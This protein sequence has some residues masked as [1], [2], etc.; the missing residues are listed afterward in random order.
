MLNYLGSKFRKFAGN[1]SGVASIEFG[2]IAPIL[3]AS[4]V[5]TLDVGTMILDRTDMQ[6]AVRTGAQYLMNGGQNLER[7]RDLVME[8]WDERPEGGYVV[9]ENFCMCDEVLH[10]CTE[11]CGDQSIPDSYIRLQAIATLEGL[12]SDREQGTEEIVRIR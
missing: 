1:K 11:L 4:M 10:V 2:F 8:A 9:A 5:L 3:A 12:I 6:S 7:A